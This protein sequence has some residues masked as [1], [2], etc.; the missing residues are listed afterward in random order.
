MMQ[1]SSLEG[2]IARRWVRSGRSHSAVVAGRMVGE[3]QECTFSKTIAPSGSYARTL[4]SYASTL[5]P[6]NLDTAAAVTTPRLIA[7]VIVD[8]P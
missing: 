6:V 2:M 4:G 8:A 5:D 7:T 3:V 1:I